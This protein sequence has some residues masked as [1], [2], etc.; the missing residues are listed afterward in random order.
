MGSIGPLA[1]EA[2]TDVGVLSALHKAWPPPA[3]TT[4]TQ[5]SQWEGH[6]RR[7]VIFAWVGVLTK[8][9][10]PLSVLSLTLV[11]P[12]HIPPHT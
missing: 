10:I 6:Y 12:T 1:Y 3:A 9:G 8:E 5:A 11:V 2:T 4:H 7:A